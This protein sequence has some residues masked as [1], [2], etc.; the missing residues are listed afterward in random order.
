[1]KNTSQV[2]QNVFRSC[3]LGVHQQVTQFTKKLIKQRNYLVE[4][5]PK[6][7]DQIESWA[8]KSF[9]EEVKNISRCSLAKSC[10]LIAL[11]D[12]AALTKEYNQ[13]A[14]FLDMGM[15]EGESYQY[16]GTKAKGP[17]ALCRSAAA[18]RHVCGN[19]GHVCEL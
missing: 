1:M 13:V 17:R 3:N 5:F 15:E 11:E 18:D 16:L 12:E 4:A 10:L 2:M 7:A 14:R 9:E 6:H 8:R 19:V